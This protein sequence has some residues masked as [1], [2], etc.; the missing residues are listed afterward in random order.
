MQLVDLDQVPQKSNSNYTFFLCFVYQ[1]NKSIHMHG[2]ATRNTALKL[3]LK[4][5]DFKVSVQ[6][7]EHDRKR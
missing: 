1:Q 2:K 6:R 3:F 7:L 4:C 5:Q